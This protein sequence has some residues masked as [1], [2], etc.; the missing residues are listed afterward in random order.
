M[1]EIAPSVEFQIYAPFEGSYE[2][3]APSTKQRPATVLL[4]LVKFPQENVYYSA[5]YALTKKTLSNMKAKNTIK[6]T[7]LPGSQ[8]CIIKMITSKQQTKT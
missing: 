6:I 1:G 7:Y 8:L 3:Q 5:S 2:R 4:L